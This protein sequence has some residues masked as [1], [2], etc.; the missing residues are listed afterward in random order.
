MVRPIRDYTQVSDA[1]SAVM[2]KA[3]V[4]RRVETVSTRQ[5]FG[6]VS[7][8][9]LIAPGDVPPF[10]TSHMDGFAVIS[11]DLEAVTRSHPA[12]LVIAGESRVGPRP[13]YKIRPGEAV[14]VA[15]GAPLPTGAD[16]VVP[17]ES[18]EVRGLE[19]LV[20]A[21][22][23]PQSYVYARGEDVRKGEVVIPKG[24]TFR[25]QDVGLVVALGFTKLKVWRKPRVSV[26]ATGSE[27]T[28]ASRPLEGKVRES[29]SPIFLRL[30]EGSGCIPVDMG[31]VGDDPRALAM[32]LR[33]AL[34]TSDFVLTLGG[35]SA[36]KRDFVVEVASSL[37]PDVII[38]GIKL[39]RGR[40]TGIARV[41]GKPVLMLPGPIQAAM[42]AF[43]VMGTPIIQA[44]SGNT[45]VGFELPC[46]MGADWECR[47]KFPNFQ[48]VVYVR[49]DWDNEVTAGP[50]SAETES[51]R[52]LADADGYVLVPEGVTRINKGSAVRVRLF[53]GF[54]Y[55][56]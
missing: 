12:R 19:I 37:K 52:L 6:R 56:L 4:E 18:A 8:S 27:L 51:L 55:V 15:T 20:R 26:I 53:P 50:L 10:P 16:A 7:A 5:A 35:T 47:R 32:I 29:H 38:H 34:R 43:L 3:R 40:V 2:A 42:N 46:R 22:H 11:R 25:A 41:K 44:L 39:D 21:A 14:Q 23:G 45:K 48:K 13:R 24:H 28:A 36:G 31:I 9:D 1:L 33:K 49:L 30:L 17:K 54:S